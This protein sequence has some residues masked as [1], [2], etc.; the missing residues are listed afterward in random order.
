MIYTV[1]TENKI[2][3][4]AKGRE[5]IAQN[6]QNLLCTIRNEVA[7]KREKG[8]N[9]SGIDSDPEGFKNFV[10]ADTYEIIEEYEPRAEIIDVNVIAIN[11]DGVS[12]E[13]V[14]NIE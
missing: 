13:V 12:I 8:R 5:R 14:I 6:V 1:N 4:R 7:Y 11:N 10:I 9:A 2:N 3:W